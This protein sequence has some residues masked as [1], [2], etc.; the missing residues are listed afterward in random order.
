MMVYYSPCLWKMW[1]LGRKGRGIAN[2]GVN[3]K[4]QTSPWSKNTWVTNHNDVS[5]TLYG[6]AHLA[7]IL[8]NFLQRTLSRHWET[9]TFQIGKNWRSPLCELYKI[10][11]QQSRQEEDGN[12][13]SHQVLQVNFRSHYPVTPWESRER[14]PG[15]TINPWR[16]WI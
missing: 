10:A 11:L 7:M 8:T 9:M 13:A 5:K 15:G 4:P 16:E 14:R 1:L 6:H 3:I 2:F 12:L